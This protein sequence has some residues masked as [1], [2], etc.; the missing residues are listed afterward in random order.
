MKKS[1]FAAVFAL[2]VGVGMI[3]L[4][5]MLIITGQV[6]EFE[7]IP[8]EIALHLAGEFLTAIILIIAS[9]LTLIKESKGNILLNIAFGSL[10]YTVIVSSGYYLQRNEL[11]MVIMF[12]VIFILTIISLILLN[13]KIAK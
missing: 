6:E 7:T 4:W 10:L 11:P 1:K 5:A 13:K 8:Y 3:G 12:S 2:V 9:L